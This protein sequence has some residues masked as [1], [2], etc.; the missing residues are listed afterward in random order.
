MGLHINPDNRWVKLADRI[1]WDEFKVKYAKLFSSDTGNV[2]KP[3]RTALG[4]LIIQTKFQFSDRE[5]AEQVA[6]NPYLQYC[7]GLL[8][9]REEAPFDAGTLVLFRKRISAEMLME[10]NEHLLTHKD[11]DNDDHTPPSGGKTND[12]STARENTNKGTLTFDATPANIRYPQDI[13]LLNEVRERLENIIFCFCKCYGLKLP[14]RYCRRARK[15]YLSF[16][17]SRKHTA[18]KI[19]RALR[20][21][22]AYVKRD[23]RYL[24][25]FM[26]DG[27]AM[28]GKDINLYFTIIKLHEQ[29]QY[30]YENR[31]HSV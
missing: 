13:S 14:R 6:E 3:L 11:D 23:L 12:A 24:E 22:L 2:V 4:A 17:K 29:Q 31:V 10:V 30:M 26:N 27:Y 25:Q 20:R 9:F 7:I 21:Q 19:R 16:A 1:L 15:E 8:G 18:Q 5:L 28:T